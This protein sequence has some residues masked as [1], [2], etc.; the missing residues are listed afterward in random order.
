MR[1]ARRRPV[2]SLS[3][4][5]ATLAFGSVQPRWSGATTI[6]AAGLRARRPVDDDREV[7]AVVEEQVVQALRR[8]GAVGGDDDAEA[9]ADQLGQAI[10][11]AACRRRRPDPSPR[12]RRAGCRAT[13]ASSRSTRTTSPRS[14]LVE[15]RVGVGVQAGERLVGIAGPRGGQGAGEVVLLGDQVDGAVAHPARL[16][17]QDLRRR[18]AARR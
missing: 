10:G 9:A 6:A 11:E 16:D 12:P 13:R 18:R 8:A 2:R 1:W 7:E 3:A 15:Q 14:S 5:I 17:E 4:T